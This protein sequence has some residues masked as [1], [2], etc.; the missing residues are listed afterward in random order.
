MKKV[1]STIFKAAMSSRDVG[2]FHER[3][4]VAFYHNNLNHLIDELPGPLGYCW[5]R[6]RSF[7]VDFLVP[8]G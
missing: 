3:N 5:Q 8:W 2:G 7:V 1:A 6:L 4:A